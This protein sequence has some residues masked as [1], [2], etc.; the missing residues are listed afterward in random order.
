MVLERLL[1]TTISYFYFSLLTS[2]CTMNE[3]ICT[4]WKFLFYLLTIYLVCIITFK[5]TELH[6][7]YFLQCWLKSAHTMWYCCQIPKAQQNSLLW[8]QWYFLPT[9]RLA[10][11]FYR[12]PTS[13]NSRQSHLRKLSIFFKLFKTCNA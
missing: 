5:S 2:F 9:T 11:K 1:G 7:S 10:F 3:I 4:N 8:L 13:G 12:M 6:W